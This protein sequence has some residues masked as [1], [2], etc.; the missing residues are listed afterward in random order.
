MQSTRPYDEKIVA[1]DTSRSR[2][3]AGTAAGRTA[4]P[5]SAS[6]S[7]RRLA[8]PGS[9]TTSTS[10]TL[11][12][13]PRSHKAALPTS[14]PDTR[15]AARTAAAS[16]TTGNSEP[17]G[18]TPPIPGVSTF[19]EGTV[20]SPQRR[21][22]LTA[23]RPRRAQGAKRHRP[24]LLRNR[25]NVVLPLCPRRAGQDVCGTGLE[26]EFGGLPSAGPTA[27]KPHPARGQQRDAADIAERRR[28]AVPAYPRTRRVARH[29]QIHQLLRFASHHNG[30]ALPQ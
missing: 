1:T 2:C 9:I 4:R 25:G 15:S 28:I 23:G 10:P 17:A 30:A 11:T 21:S 26:G 18:A 24:S 27:A 16:T 3:T 13:S 6:C 20:G 29:E 14:T 5:A 22:G 7:R 19:T 12:G 8:S